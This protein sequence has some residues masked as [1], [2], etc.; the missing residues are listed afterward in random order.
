MNEV[1]RRK[2]S[3]AVLYL[4]V[5]V[6]SVRVLMIAGTLGY[7][8]IVSLS[9]HS[10]YFISFMSLIT[11]PLKCSLQLFARFVPEQRMP[12]RLATQLTLS[13]VL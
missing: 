12:T 4:P 7:N 2:C 13:L 6:S 11:G 10:K 8:L 3:D 5:S 1:K 9:I